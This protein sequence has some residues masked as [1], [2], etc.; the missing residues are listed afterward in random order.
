MR[1]R[2]QSGALQGSLQLRIEADMA[3]KER[4]DKFSATTARK[5]AQ[6]AAYICSNPKCRRLTI[7]PDT[8]DLSR[9][10]SAGKASHIKAASPGGPRYDPLQSSAQRKGIANAIWLCGACADFIDKNQGKS[11]PVQQIENWKKDH[12]SLIKDCLEGE[13]RAVFQ[14]GTEKQDYQV[15]LGVIQILKDKGFLF[16]PYPQESHRYVVESMKELRRDFTL[17]VTRAAPS[18]KLAVTIESIIHACRHYMNSTKPD[19][20]FEEMN[21]RLS[22]VRKIVGINIHELCTFYDL[23]P[24]KEL[25]AITPVAT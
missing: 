1:D 13:K 22:A 20:G 25:S 16:A 21:D 4:E 11:Y 2:A 17:L 6:R 9:S 5:V 14:F 15:A 23:D 24:G 10:I 7:G 12:E 18:S 3:T 19:V 8:A